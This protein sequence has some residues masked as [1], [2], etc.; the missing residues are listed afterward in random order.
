MNPAAQASRPGRRLWRWV[1]VGLGVCLA[2]IVALALVLASY[3]TLDRNAA[4]LKRQVMTAIPAGWKTKVQLSVGPTTL[5][6]V[7]AALA[8]AHGR[9][10]ADARLALGAVHQASVGVYQCAERAPEWSRAR[11][12]ERVDRAMQERG[13][14]RLVGVADTDG[15]VLVF[16][17]PAADND[18]VIELSLVVIHQREL[19]VVSAQVDATVVQEL[20]RRHAANGL[21][22]RL[23]L[24]RLAD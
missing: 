9:D 17:P 11:L 5:G 19:V 23:R 8:F 10:L 21:P 3:I 13:W 4:A 24:A 18:H 7:Q 15:T 20:V 12:F 22:S 2:P 6:A 1:L 14:V 16:T